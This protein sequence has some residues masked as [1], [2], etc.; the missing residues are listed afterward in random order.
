MLFRIFATRKTKSL[1]SDTVLFIA[2]V[3]TAV[4]VYFISLSLS[5]NKFKEVEA[6]LSQLDK[7]K[8]MAQN[9]LSEV[10]EQLLKSEQFLS[11]E[12]NKASQLTSDLSQVKANNLNNEKRLLEQKQELEQLEQRFK[13]EFENLANKILE[14]KSQKF[15]EQNK[16]NLDII[17]NPLKERIKDFEEK[18]DK[19]YKAESTERISLKEQIKNL[20]DLN[21][22]LSQDANNLVTALKGDTKKQGDW[23]EVVLDRI[24]EISGLEGGREYQKQFVTENVEGDKIK[25]DVIVFLPDEKHLVIDS[26][27]SLLAYN[28]FTAAVSEEDKLRFAKLH[29]ESVRAHIRGLSDKKYQTSDKLNTPD[30]VLLFMPIESAFSIA[31]QTDNDLYSFAWDR[32]IIVVSPTTLLATLRTVA[33]IWKQERQTKNALLIAEEGGKLYDK[34]VGFVEDL[35]SIGKKMDDAKINYS[36]AMKKL[37]D[38]S[39]NLVKRAEKMRELG[40][41]TSKALPQKL[42]ERGNDE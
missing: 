38:G 6:R 9:S 2:V 34:F 22:Q 14:D 12:R 23:G 10:R 16:N 39:G 18:V 3:V 13:T 36:E 8:A 5:A 32:K 37:T 33:S 7:E 1:M 27:V 25:P 21:K 4:L 41:K 29:I 35:I 17:L 42:V 26:K 24:L 30:F 19:T 20:L 31:L 40:A 15:T 28:N 11:E